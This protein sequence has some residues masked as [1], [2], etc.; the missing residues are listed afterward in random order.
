MKSPY[1]TMTESNSYSFSQFQYDGYTS[2]PLVT[3]YNSV[4]LA[5]F[6]YRA[7]PLETF[8]FDQSKE[9]LSMYL[10]KADMM[11]FLYWNIMLRWVPHLVPVQRVP[12]FAWGWGQFLGS[13][14]LLLKSELANGTYSTVP[15]LKNCWWPLKDSQASA[16]LGEEVRGKFAVS[17]TCGG[18]PLSSFIGG[19]KS[20]DF[21]PLFPFYS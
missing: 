19:T 3:G 13:F 21:H 16:T 6:D 17:P 7:E 18:V 11:P 15:F 9:R 8:P 20:S 5:E 1:I 10:M 12:T 2:C 14:Q 4:I